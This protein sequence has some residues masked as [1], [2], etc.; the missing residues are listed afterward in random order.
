MNDKVLFGDE[1]EDTD[2]YDSEAIYTVLEYGVDIW[3]DD[4]PEIWLTS[5]ENYDFGVG[6]ENAFGD[7]PGIEHTVTTRT[8]KNIA[9]CENQFEAGSVGLLRLKSCG[10]DWTQGMAL[11][12]AFR[13]SSLN[14]V[15]LNYTEAR[16]MSS[17]IF[18]ACNYRVM[19]PDSKFMFHTGTFGGEFTGTQIDTE[20]RE[21]QKAQE[22]MLDIYCEAMD[23]PG[24]VY[25]G[26]P[27]TIKRAWLIEQMKSHEEVYLTAEEAVQYGFAHAIF[28]GDWEKLREFEEV[29][30]EP[31]EMVGSDLG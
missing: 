9:I 6:S 26:K 1:E 13:L 30:D 10:G 24:A 29:D 11:F 14:W 25:A 7:E 23:E 4:G 27:D 20:Y 19:M 5:V 18:C 12:N 8:L 3:S 22:R 16:S 15:A 2:S 28:D 31:A 17:L 21:W